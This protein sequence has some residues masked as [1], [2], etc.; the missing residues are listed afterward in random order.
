MAT[1]GTLEQ[2]VTTFPYKSKGR[3][4]SPGLGAHTSTGRMTPIQAAFTLHPAKPCLG[5]TATPPTPALSWAEVVTPLR[6]QG[7]WALG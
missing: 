2:A 7:R 6:S 5:A 3:G 1:L 4:V